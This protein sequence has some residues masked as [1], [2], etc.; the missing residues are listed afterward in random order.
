MLYGF[1][2]FTLQPNISALPKN[3]YYQLMILYKNNVNRLTE[4]SAKQFHQC[5]YQ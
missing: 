3:T 4:S 5:P 1:F 2:K